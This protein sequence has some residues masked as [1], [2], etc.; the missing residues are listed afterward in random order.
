MILGVWLLCATC[1]S[2][3]SEVGSSQPPPAISRYTYEAILN[4]GSGKATST[5]YQIAGALQPVAVGSAT[6]LNYQH[7]TQ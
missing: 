2:K 7:E 6:S 3:K 1:K 5:N 4:S